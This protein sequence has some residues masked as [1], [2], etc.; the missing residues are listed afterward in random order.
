L[1]TAAFH[2]AQL[3]Q[4]RLL[5]PWERILTTWIYDLFKAIVLILFR[6]TISLQ[7]TGN[8]QIPQCSQL[9][10]AAN[11]ISW[12][13][14]LLIGASINRRVNFVAKE[15]LFYNKLF[16]QLLRRL[17]AI[18]V[19]RRKVSLEFLR[20]ADRILKQNEILAIFPEGTRSRNGQLG[21]A[22]SGAAFV[23]MRSGAPIL[24]VGI[25]G[26]EKIRGI[27]WLLHRPKVTVN[28]GQVFYIEQSSPKIT[29]EDL[30]TA[31]HLIMLKIAELLPAQYRGIYENQAGYTRL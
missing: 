27:T 30:D 8:Y 16:T 25:S 7:V 2:T 9:I 11:H 22:F 31:T 18:P 19:H 4:C 28:I 10:I 14:P 17:G 12:V 24:P 21:A 6:L 20:E 26:T 15:E 1:N 5:L 23:A 29:T 13:D 3:N